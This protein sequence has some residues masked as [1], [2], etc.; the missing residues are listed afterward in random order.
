MKTFYTYGEALER[1]AVL[2]KENAIA[3]ALL[4]RWI[5]DVPSREIAKKRADRRSLGRG[6]SRE[7]CAKGG[8]NSTRTKKQ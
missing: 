2:E 1:I 6:P 5:A 3:E 4:L 7:A 8:R